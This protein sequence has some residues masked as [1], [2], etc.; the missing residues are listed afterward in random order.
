MTQAHFPTECFI[1]GNHGTLRVCA[2]TGAILEYEPDEDGSYDEIARIDIGEW[3]SHYPDE[4]I[5]GTYVD[6]LDVAYWGKD[7]SYEKPIRDRGG[8][9][10]LPFQTGDDGITVWYGAIVDKDEDAELAR[11]GHVVIFDN[12]DNSLVMNADLSADTML[13]LGRFLIAK[14]YRLPFED[15]VD[16][17]N[18]TQ[19]IQEFSDAG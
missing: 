3:N 6:I 18:V 7:G 16:P 5:N 8:D 19:I 17:V 15:G 11:A 10:P 2:Y 12:R 14:S 1:T 13:M 4:K 9:N